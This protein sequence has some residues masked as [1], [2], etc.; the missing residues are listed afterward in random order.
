MSSGTPWR[1]LHAW[2]D[3]ENV[4][5]SMSGYDEALATLYRA[6][7][8]DFVS[9]RKRLAK[10]L[11][12]S[13]D[14]EG[15]RRLGQRSRPN[16]SA[17]TVN[18]LYWQA[19]PEFDAMVASAAP[20]RAGG[21]AGGAE[22][23]EALNVLRARASKILEQAGH[24]ASDATLRR[25]MTTLSALAASGSFAPDAPGTLSADRDPPGFE[26][27]GIGDAETG[28]APE[29]SVTASRA[30]VAPPHR[31]KASA[32]KEASSSERDRQRRE[33]AVARER[34]RL[35]HERAEKEREERERERKQRAEERRKIRSELEAA[36]RDVDAKECLVDD[37][38]KELTRA[39]QARD[40]ARKKAEAVRERLAAL[41]DD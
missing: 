32:A 3:R 14:S 41:G 38:R 26:A 15:A 8:G 33:Q 28:V 10:D 5:L 25:V 22:H 7:L 30:P 24:A 11:K 16:I 20:L 17:W 2:G 19:R 9:E 21:L 1:G 18:Q 29:S 23:R 37:Q 35:E 31:A 6:P 39:E 34:E 12:A 13:G 40:R 4:A 27:V 36:E